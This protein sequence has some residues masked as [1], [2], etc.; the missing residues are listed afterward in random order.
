MVLIKKHEN[1]E[2]AKMDIFHHFEQKVQKPR[3]GRGRGVKCLFCEITVILYNL[4]CLKLAFLSEVFC[5][6]IWLYYLF[7]IC[8][9]PEFDSS[10]PEALS[11][12]GMEVSIKTYTIFY[13]HLSL[14]YVDQI[15]FSQ[16]SQ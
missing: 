8:L 16:T 2:N 13:L 9:I 1:L 15:H 14:C 3:R 5:L 4:T 12:E 10:F 11:L 6:V 7:L